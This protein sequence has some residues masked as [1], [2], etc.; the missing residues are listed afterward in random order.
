[1]P[2]PLFL[3]VM[4]VPLDEYNTYSSEKKD[5]FQRLAQKKLAQLHESD[6]NAYCQLTVENETSID[7]T[8]SAW[9]IAEEEKEQF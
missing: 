5:R 9:E 7:E 6:I 1:M 4:K 3:K 2:N 8:K